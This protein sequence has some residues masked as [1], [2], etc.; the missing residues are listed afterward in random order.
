M[1]RMLRRFVGSGLLVLA[2]ASA[3][4]GESEDRI[5]ALVDQRHASMSD[6]AMLV[7]DRQPPLDYRN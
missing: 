3:G 7:G 2:A 4:A 6:V 1:S 5:L